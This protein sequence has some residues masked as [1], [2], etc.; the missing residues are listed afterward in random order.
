M[1]RS[2]SI[3]ITGMKSNSDALSTIAN[4][5]AN[6]QTVGYKMQQAVFEELFFQAYGAASSPNL[7]NGGTN[8]MEIGNGVKMGSVKSIHSQGNIVNTGNKTDMAIQGEGFFVVGDAN[9]QNQQYTRAGNFVVNRDNQLVSKTGEYVLGWNMDPLTG[10]I[11]TGSKLSPL[12]IDLGTINAPTQSTQMS[13][14]G[15]LNVQGGIGD[16][17]GMQSPSWDS[18]GGR[19]DINYDF[20]K[21]GGNTFRYV[22]TPLDAFIPSAS[23]KQAVLKP[24]SGIAASLQKGNYNIATAAGGPGQVTFTVTGPG[25]VNFT[26]TVNDVNQT[27]TLKDASNNTWFTVNYASGGVPSSATFP[28]GEAGDMTFNT[29]G[30]L[31]TITGSGA[32]GNPMVTYTSPTTGSPV[33]INV[34]MSYITGLSADNAILMKGTNGQGASVLSDFALSDNGFVTGYYTDGTVRDIGQVSLAFFGNPAGLSRSGAG[35]F[36][37]TANSGTPDIGTSGTGSRGV[38][39]ALATE[40]SNV[41][42]ATEFVNMM[43]S[44]KAYQANTKIIQTSNEV[45]QEVI[46]LIR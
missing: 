26:Q 32:G 27:V 20:I 33:N 14:K 7:K 11:A 6:D 42:M 31:S 17:Y 16:V 46:S 3:G 18:L 34:D 13:L 45:L 15:N 37:T 38:I 28:V 35:N 19:H 4:N 21:T 41:D 36:Q 22:A 9:G 30:Q 43:T 8:P 5:I 1:L 12:K 23:I 2:M 25:G 44:Q 39:K 29:T 24:S 10:N 40:S